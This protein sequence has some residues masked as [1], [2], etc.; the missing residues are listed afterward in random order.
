MIIVFILFLWTRQ[1]VSFFPLLHHIDKMVLLFFIWTG[2]LC[3]P[4][5]HAVLSLLSPTRSETLSKAWALTGSTSSLETIS[6]LPKNAFAWWMFLLSL[7]LFFS[8]LR[9]LC[10]ER[11]MLKRLVFVMIGIGVI[12][13]VYGL[14]QALVPS[15]GVLWVDYVQ[16]YLGTA[17]GTF[18]N[19]N[20]FAA[21]IEMVWPLALGL[22]LAMTGRV[23]SLK[24]ALGSDRLNRQALMALSIIVFLLAL[25]FTRSRAGIISGL[26]GFLAFSIMAQTGMK[27]M[28]LQTRVL[29]GGIILLL[30]IY[31]MTIGVAPIMQR[32]LTLGGDSG[33][34]VDIWRNSLPIIKDHSLG[35]GLRNYENVF[36]VYN[37]SLTSDKM[38]NHAH[39]DYL[40]LLI[41][42]GW[43][44]FFAIMSGFIIFLLKS[45]R[46]IR[47]LNF[48]KDPFRSYL[49]VGAF[50]GLISMTVHSLFDFNL[51]I[52][53]NCLYV[54]VLMAI[55]SACTQPQDNCVKVQ[56]LRCAAFI[57]TTECE[58]YAADGTRVSGILGTCEP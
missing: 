13:A 52:P 10:S 21:F 6:Y 56:H 25:I 39:N 11:K 30:C 32:F 50:S 45:T 47:Q 14:I 29:L 58:K 33:S 35:I 5:P 37:Q 57:V 12:E 17:R 49:A 41:E 54:V 27:A 55:L 42:T 40:Q 31:T 51:Q 28:A 46:R 20:N 9:S 22:T 48:R 26:I 8:V 1:D 19:R 7:L 16:D 38:V 34:R 36:P 23:T 43:I 4:F 24:E 53:A 44:G 18:I 2:F 15:M 3:I